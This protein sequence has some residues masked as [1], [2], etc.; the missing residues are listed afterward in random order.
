MTASPEIVDLFARVLAKGV[1]RLLRRG[2]DRGY[3]EVEEDT[4]SLRGRILVGE[5]VRRNL[6]RRPHAAC[7]FDELRHDV[8]HNQIIKA[9]LQRLLEAERLSV[10]LAEELRKLYR[11]LDGITNIRLSGGLFRR[12]QFSRN[13]GHYDLLLRVC[14]LIYECLL[15]EE[16]EKKSKF[17]DILDNVE[18]M[19]TIFEDFV[20][21]F[22]RTG[23][24]EFTVRSEVITWDAAA[25]DPLHM[26]YLPPQMVT[27]VSLRSL[28]RT[29]VIDTKYY[30]KTLSRYKGN[31]K[32]WS[33]NLYQLFAYL[34]NLERHGGPDATADGVLLY[35]AVGQGIDLQY[36]IGGHRLRVK[37]VDLDVHWRQIHTELL[38]II[39]ANRCRGDQPL[40]SSDMSESAAAKGSRS[41]R[42]ESY[43]SSLASIAGRLLISIVY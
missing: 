16:R 13:T 23:Q 32:I 6:L 12:V 26:S 24:T 22:F 27:D 28:S 21:D 36:I 1:R 9:T 42:L 2:L 18:K 40:I 4:A 25:M 43:V 30:R 15:R 38:G 8:L 3:V 14:G 39:Q 5:T 41:A 37:T 29:I 19:S 10:E 20:R 33:P 35:P 11:P 17:P 31:E 7:R 34:K